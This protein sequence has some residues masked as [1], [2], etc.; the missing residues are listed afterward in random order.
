M[1]LTDHGGLERRLTMRGKDL[2]LPTTLRC[3][4]PLA[5]HENES[6]SGNACRRPSRMAH[7][8]LSA[9][10]KSAE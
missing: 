10:L 6:A 3:P 7:P 9:C 4:A 5:K 1:V 2:P 8:V